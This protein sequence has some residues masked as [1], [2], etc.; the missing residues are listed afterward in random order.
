MLLETTKEKMPEVRDFV[1]LH[2]HTIYSTLDGMCKLEPLVDRAKEL[3]QTALAITDH[4]HSGGCLE[5]QRVCKKKGIKSLLGAELY[6]TP[7]M[8][9]A[10][11]PIEER[12]A[13]GIYDIIKDDDLRGQ[14]DW[15]LAERKRD[16]KTGEEYWKLVQDAGGGRGGVIKAFTKKEISAFKR[17]N[18]KL[19]KEH[20]YDMHQFHLIVIAM[21]TKG[22]QNLCAIQSVASRDCQ[23]NGRAMADLN[24][25]K[26]YNEGLLVTSAC[27]ASRFS[28]LVQQKKLDQ[29]EKEIL[30]YKEVFGDRFYLEL[31]PLT[32]PQQV[33]TNAFYM[34]MHEK[35][36]IPVIATSDVH[37]IMKE[38]HDDHDTFLCI[39]M[40]KLKDETK[41]KE[42]YIKT[43]KKDPEGRG[44]KPRMRYSNDYWLRSK[45]E[46]VE[47]FLNQIDNSHM[48]FRSEEDPLDSDAYRDLFVEALET[49]AD[50]A[51]RVD[52]DILIGSNV[53]LYPKVK[54]VPKG[55]TSDSWLM[56]EAVEGLQ[57]YT[58]KMEKAGTPIDYDK[59]M[60]RVIDEM[61]VIT[62]KHYS[63]YFLG[64]QEYANW[65]N[66]IDPETGYPHCAVGPGRGS[67]GGSLVLFLIGIT[68]NIDPIKYQLMFSR[69][70]TMDRTS[71]PDIDLDFQWSRRPY[72]IH[73]L[74]DVYGKDHVCHIGAWTTESIYTGIKD[75][76]RVLD[77]PI[78]VSDKINKK[79][80]A[81]ANNDP[82]AC[83]KFFDDMDSNEFKALEEKNK[84]LFRLARK[85]EGS[86]R[87]WTT[88]AS[89]V[90]ACPK[91]LLGLIPTRYDAKKNETVALFTGVELE[92]INLIKYDILGL[93]TN[94]LIQMT[95][96]SIGKDFDWLYEHA[97]I[98][99]KK[100]YS[101]IRSG[102][103]EG[104]FQVESSMM[105]GLIKDIKPESIND[106]MAI[107]SLGR[108]GPLSANMPQN[109]AAVKNG[110]KEISYPIRGCE[111]IL[112]ETHGTTCYQEQL[113][114]ISKKVSGFDDGQADSITRK[115]V[116]KKKE[117]L[118]PMMMRCH[119]FGKRNCEGPEDWEQDD[120]APWYD[121]DGHYGGEI[122]GAV[123][124]GYT[125]EEM[126]K[127]FDAIMG[128]A[129][130]AFNKSH[131]CA[132]SYITF[133][134]AYLKAH[135]PA[136]Y[137]ASVLSMADTDEKKD[138]YMRATEALGI[139]ITVP[140][141]NH[142]KEDFTA[143]DDHTIA[144]G[145]ASIKG[146][147]DVADIIA[148]APYQSVKDAMDRLPGKSFNKRIAEN[149]IKAGAFDFE[150]RNRK[151]LLNEFTT[152]RNETRTKSQQEE[153]IED[154]TWD[155][156]DCMQMESET[157]G[158]S[159]TYEP[160]WKG[161]LP[162]EVLKGNCTFKSIKKH[163]TKSSHKTM[164][165]LTVTNEAYDME[166]LV[167][168]R[169]YPKFSRIL[170]NYEAGSIYYVEGKM[171]DDSKKLIINKIE[172]P[173]AAGEDAPAVNAGGMPT[174]S[175]DD[176]IIPF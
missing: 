13:L 97:K 86:I 3:G 40:G 154:L 119:I 64:V 107:N 152:A 75:F 48:I 29:A 78:S 160:A 53:T 146:V 69:F 134:T 123:A 28:R 77:L 38:D 138:L 20:A 9:T 56:A 120:N 22:W 128:F 133:L 170:E 149:L 84:E 15:K 61:A 21:N 10:A 71:P 148:N 41:N 118:F 12:D 127:Y 106:L 57:K 132:Y 44:W 36:G 60:D 142:S 24:L 157:L 49:T 45:E 126:K 103:T 135:Y 121:P 112:D 130:Y 109:Y 92:S 4:G 165:M 101:L 144:Y 76:A 100:T 172:P 35:H 131:A 26:K 176:V 147:K 93:K 129:Q 104:V 162:G 116:A 7:D 117:S 105:K 83:F 168:P 42:L 11:L 70:L 82:K 25:L 18:E 33:I 58:A 51:A 34:Q 81:L 102:K 23:Y 175:F 73:H 63:D 124:N 174:F 151:K 94:D 37:Y 88:H 31:Q 141:V 2:V 74:E 1:H 66:S 108:P 39:A 110:E 122:K 65:S 99:D 79:L 155:K 161:A 166:A 46:M 156:L 98:N 139:K 125:V 43:H 19:F 140:D 47:G 169:E 68:H 80:Q 137:M 55:F 111:D 163:I 54:N 136:Q 164:C 158:R 114:L 159:I 173:R 52:D 62:T 96:K 115:I 89:G 16:L 17:K 143:V 171:S 145:L 50:F 113:M 72:V 67:A 6:T 5:F 87:Q 14:V 167:F 32:L 85:F 150:D 90:I 91:S 59:Y 95:L 27:V 30:A 153:L 8:K